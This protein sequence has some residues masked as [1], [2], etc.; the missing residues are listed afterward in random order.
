MPWPN[1]VASSDRGGMGLGLK[2][3]PSHT[4]PPHHLK[5]DICPRI[6]EFERLSKQG[7]WL[8]SES[9]GSDRKKG[10][11]KRRKENP[12]PAKDLTAV[13]A[14]E[15]NSWVPRT[16]PD[17]RR[18]VCQC[19]LPGPRELPLTPCD[20]PSDPGRAELPAPF[21]SCTAFSQVCRNINGCSYNRG[22]PPVISVSPAGSCCLL[23]DPDRVSR[24]RFSASEFSPGP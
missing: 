4:H 14:K 23:P 2:G 1:L 16:R 24:K 18:A 10:N 5:E 21:P 15:H 19:G 11:T 17:L 7:G 3:P 8:S 13:L 20:P 12:N 22:P 6:E 9:E